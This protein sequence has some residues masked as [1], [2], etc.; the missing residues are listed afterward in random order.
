MQSCTRDDTHT[1]SR[2]HGCGQHHPM[3]RSPP[4]RSW[5]WEARTLVD[6]T[7]QLPDEPGPKINTDA[8]GRVHQQNISS[9]I[10]QPPSTCTEHATALIL[11]NLR[12][13]T[14]TL[15]GLSLPRLYFHIKIVMQSLVYICYLPLDLAIHQRFFNT[16]LNYHS[17]SAIR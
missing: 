15:S 14:R 8:R 6:Q 4:C 9:N 3:P 2:G 7:S 11:L 17:N 16:K 1:T 5:A 10:R 12:I 13:T